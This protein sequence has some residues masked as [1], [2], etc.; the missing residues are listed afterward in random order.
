MRRISPLKRTARAILERVSVYAPAHKDARKVM[1]IEKRE[2]SRI[3][4]PSRRHLDDAMHWLSKAQ[5]SSG[6]GGVAWGYRT[7]RPIRTNLAM[8]WVAP[9]PETT[10]YIIPTMLRYA[11]ASGDD[12][13]VERAHRMIAWELSIQLADGGFQG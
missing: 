12:E 5:D 7:R 4:E 10:G 13:W 11:D 6:T 9:Y 2:T 8:G 3:V 1:Q